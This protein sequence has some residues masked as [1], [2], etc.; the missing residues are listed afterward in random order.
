MSLSSLLFPSSSPAP[1]SSLFSCPLPPTPTPAPAPTPDDDPLVDPKASALQIKDRKAR[2]IFVGNVS[3]EANRK[4]VEKYFSKFGKVE[5]V[6]ERS[7][8]VGEEG[9]RGVKGKVIGKIWKKNADSK[10]CYVLFIEKEVGVYI[11]LFIVI[12][13]GY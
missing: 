9:K 11:V 3:L 12:E 13:M 5:K 4:K 1:L 10:N 6:W 8:P 7:V 2:T